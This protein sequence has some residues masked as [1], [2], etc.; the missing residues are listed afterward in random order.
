[1]E[2]STILITMSAASDQ[3]LALVERR[4]E[5]HL[6]VTR[7]RLVELR[8]DLP[9]VYAGVKKQRI[10]RQRKAIPLQLHVHESDVEGPAIVRDEQR[11]GFLRGAVPLHEVQELLPRLPAH[12]TS[13]TALQYATPRTTPHTAL[14]G[15]WQ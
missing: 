9:G 10:V 11:Y 5:A 13:H 1:M 4:V 7:Q 8:E 15:M 6:S 12:D 3:G 14:C 2:E